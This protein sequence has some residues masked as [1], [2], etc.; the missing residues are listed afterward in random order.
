MGVTINVN[1]IDKRI[2]PVPM[3]GVIQPGMTK[4]LHG[5]G[6]PYVKDPSKRGN[7]IIDFDIVFPEKLDVSE[8][9]RR[10][11]ERHLPKFNR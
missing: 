5:E 10:I 2:V 4:V 11:F 1:T 6:L 8:T 9:E 3:K 7:L